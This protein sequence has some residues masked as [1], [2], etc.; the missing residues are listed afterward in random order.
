MS[1]PLIINGFPV[2][3]LRISQWREID[4]K[5]QKKQ[6]PQT[7]I[8]AN[9]QRPLA[10]LNGVVFKN[11]F[12]TNYSIHC[13]LQ[14][15]AMVLKSKH[16][17]TTYA[18][19]MLSLNIP[20]VASNLMNIH[21]GGVVSKRANIRFVNFRNHSKLLFDPWSV[22]SYP[23]ASRGPLFDLA[24]LIFDWKNPCFP[25]DTPRAQTAN[26]SDFIIMQ[27]HES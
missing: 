17:S 23:N 21:N 4:K 10:S 11:F 12:H 7:E 18:K 15:Q 3:S 2:R 14:P 8:N 20:Q 22:F 1:D 13:L 19:K 27:D 9:S 26:F 25:P 5:R 24:K 6:N 16:K